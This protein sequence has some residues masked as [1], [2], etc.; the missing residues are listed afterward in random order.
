MAREEDDNYISVGGWMWI[1]FVTALPCIGLIMMIVW[2]FAGNNQ[3]RKNYF[4]AI[5]A[6]F[7]IALIVVAI[8]A[9]ATESP[10]IQKWLQS[11]STKP[12]SSPAR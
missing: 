7:V 10:E 5:F 3:T 11:W 12:A 4:R 8:I 2:A 6:W 9:L 1:M